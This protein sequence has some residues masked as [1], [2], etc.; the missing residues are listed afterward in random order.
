VDWDLSSDFEAN[1]V[2]KYKV[3]SGDPLQLGFNSYSITGGVGVPILYIDGDILIDDNI[4]N[5]NP[6]NGRLLIV[7]SGDVDVRPSV[8]TVI[9][10]L[11]N[12]SKNP[13]IQ[14]GIIANGTIKFDSGLSD[15]ATSD[16]HDNPVMVSA[17]LISNDGNPDGGILSSRDLYHDNNLRI[18][19]LSAKAYNK[20]LY[21]IASLEREKSQDSLYFTG[22]TD[23]K[24]SWEYIY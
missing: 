24:M 15:V 11:Y 12:M 2:Y 9:T 16:S 5:T 18:P 19:A 8:G 17:P 23:I 14:A 4:V 7:V 21:Y 1:T 3:S 20:Y 13:D 22:L 6:N 10:P